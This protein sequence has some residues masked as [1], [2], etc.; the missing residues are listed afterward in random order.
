MESTD[1][2]N[3]GNGKSVDQEHE[4]SVQ[5]PD[6]EKR[7]QELEAQVKEKE[8]RYLYLYAEFENFKKRAVK[9]RADLLKFGWESLAQELLQT[10]DNLERALA[11]TPAN[12]DKNLI[13]GLNMVLNQFKSTLQKQGVQQIESL[14]KNFDPNLHE[15]IGQEK[16]DLPAGTITQEHL[17][18]YTLHGRLL[19]PARVVVS[20]GSPETKSS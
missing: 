13:E 2:H 14:K 6:Y 20:E 5:A 4:P 19:R 10:I 16:S 1:N 9:E 8:S 11:H 12:T 3:V 7:I 18:G 15:A 17:R